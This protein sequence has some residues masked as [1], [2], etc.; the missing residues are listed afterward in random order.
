MPFDC[1]VVFDAAFALLLLS[2]LRILFCYF[3]DLLF[4]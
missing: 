1:F 3:S 4:M 2:A